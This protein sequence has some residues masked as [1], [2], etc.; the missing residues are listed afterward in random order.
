MRLDMGNKAVDSFIAGVM[1]SLDRN[2]NSVGAAAV[3]ARTAVK[4][5]NPLGWTRR[6]V[7]RIPVNGANVKVV[8]GA[9]RAVQSQVNPVPAYSLDKGARTELPLLLQ[10]SHRPT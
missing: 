7:I 10:L 8:D 5:F 3:A 6:E 1:Q 2:V 9:G 4:L